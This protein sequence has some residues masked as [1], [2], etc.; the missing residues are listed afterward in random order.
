MCD[1][2]FVCTGGTRTRAVRERERARERERVLSCGDARAGGQRKRAR[3]GAPAAA[4]SAGG[5]GDGAL[6]AC[7]RAAAGCCCRGYGSRCRLCRWRASTHTYGRARAPHAAPARDCVHAAQR[8]AAAWAAR[9]GI[10]ARARAATA[11]TVAAAAAVVAA[12]AAARL[13]VRC[14]SVALRS[15]IVVFV[16]SS[17][18]CSFRVRALEQ[19][20]FARLLGG[21]WAR[22][23]G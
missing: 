9:A 22:W 20:S 4:A 21:A 10:Q 7:V 5:G 18:G 11:G 8:M 14:A 12:A 17:G 19:P 6:R 23:G 2:V 16:F 13:L 3:G 15:H 1:N